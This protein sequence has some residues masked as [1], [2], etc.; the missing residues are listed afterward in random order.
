VAIAIEVIEAVNKLSIQHSASPIR[1]T[2][3]LSIGLATIIP[4][5]GLEPNTL[6]RLADEALYQSKREGRN[7]YTVFTETVKSS[8]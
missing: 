1:K 7:R 3:S 6:V 4:V 2:V 5:V 8:V